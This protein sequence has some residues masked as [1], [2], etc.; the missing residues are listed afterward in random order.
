MEKEIMARTA[1]IIPLSA[2]SADVKLPGLK[3]FFGGYNLHSSLVANRK[4]HDD[5]LKFAALHGIKPTLEV[6]P[7]NEEGWTQALHKLESG[8]IRYRAVLVN[9]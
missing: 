9:E 5:M 3:L 2:S 8:K 1:T 4:E 6:F 7:M